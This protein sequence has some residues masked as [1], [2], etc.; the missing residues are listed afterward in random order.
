MRK[1]EKE[2]N[3]RETRIKMSLELD[4]PN[5]GI[6]I[7]GS[8]IGFFDHML[9]TFCVHGGFVITLEM[10]GDIDVDTHHSVEDA[11]IVLGALFA[12]IL[13]DRS[14]IRRFGEAH[15]PMDESLAFAAVDISGRP[16]L[17]FDGEVNTP[18]IGCYDTALTKEFFG[19]LA[20]NMGITLHIKLLCGENAHHMTEAIYKAA[21]RALAK[22]AEKTDGGVLSAKGV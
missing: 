1:A 19:A 13:G 14:A 8:G 21:A 2:R 15:V 20:F 16:Y 3:T 6:L 9:N 5:N 4:R 12:E 18:K 22:A 11:G 7:G 10:T 17:V